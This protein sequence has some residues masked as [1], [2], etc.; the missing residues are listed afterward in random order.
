MKP[1][2]TLAALLAIGGLAFG[3]FHLMDAG[4][5]EPVEVTEEEPEAA[6]DPES[7]TEVDAEEVSDAAGAIASLNSEMEFFQERFDRLGNSIDADRVA[8]FE[9]TLARLTGRF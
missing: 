4:P 6:N 9:R 7:A 8:G 1:V 3:A 2:S 5:E